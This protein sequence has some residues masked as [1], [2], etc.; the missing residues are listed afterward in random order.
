MAHY[1]GKDVYVK[2]GTTVVGTDQR[3]LDVKDSI[4]LI[5]TTAGADT[6]ESHITGVAKADITLKLLDENTTGTAIK[7]TLYRGAAGTLEF[8]P[9]GTAAGKPKYSCLATVVN[10]AIAYPYD[11]AVEYTVSM[12]KNGAWVANND[13]SQSVYP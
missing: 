2:F 4:Q 12:T 3:S 11:K 8:G 5:P 9:Q 13:I 7:Q 1:S 6:D 10:V